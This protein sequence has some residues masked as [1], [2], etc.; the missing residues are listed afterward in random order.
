MKSWIKRTTVLIYTTVALCAV[1][2]SLVGVKILVIQI[3]SPLNG[4]SWR[5]GS[6]YILMFSLNI[7]SEIF[8]FSIYFTSHSRLRQVLIKSLSRCYCRHI[9]VNC[10]NC[11]FSRFYHISKLKK[12]KKD[13]L[14]CKCRRLRTYLKI[15]AEISWRLW[16]I[17]ISFN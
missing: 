11:C 4:H 5:Q 17:S 1:H 14:T 10:L 3:F 6:C 15:S 13:T 8:H 12:T 7:W 9:H 2:P 16:G